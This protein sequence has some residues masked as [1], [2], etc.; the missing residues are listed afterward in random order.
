MAGNIR[1]HNKFHAYTHYTDPVPG[2]PGSAMDPIASAEFPFLGNLYVAGCLSA[3]GWLDD[4]GTCRKFL[5]EEE[6]G[7][8]KVKICGDHMEGALHYSHVNYNTTL[9]YD[10]KRLEVDFQEDTF[11]TITCDESEYHIMP[12][13]LSAGCVTSVRFMNPSANGDV[14]LA[15]HPHMT[16][17]CRRPCILSAGEE[18]I[19]SMTSFSN[20]L[21]SVVCIWKEREFELEEPFIKYSPTITFTDTYNYHVIDSCEPIIYKFI[22]EDETDIAKLTLNDTVVLLGNIGNELIWDDTSWST[23]EQTITSVNG[24]PNIFELYY[25]F[26]TRAGG[27]S[28]DQIY[29]AKEL[30]DNSRRLILGDTQ[31]FSYSGCTF[32]VQYRA[33]GSILFNIAVGGT[34]LIAGTPDP[35]DQMDSITVT[36]SEY[37]YVNGEYTHDG[38]YVDDHYTGDS[39]D[40]NNVLK[41]RVWVKKLQPFDPMYNAGKDQ[42][43]TIE[44]HASGSVE[45]WILKNPTGQWLYKNMIKDYPGYRNYPLQ[46]SWTPVVTTIGG[47]VELHIVGQNIYMFDGL[48][49]RIGSPTPLVDE[50]IELAHTGDMYGECFSDWIGYEVQNIN[51]RATPENTA[52]TDDSERVLAFVTP[53]H[54]VD[55]DHPA[56]VFDP[57]EYTATTNNPTRYRVGDLIRVYTEPGDQEMHTKYT[58]TSSGPKSSTDNRFTSGGTFRVIDKGPRAI[59]QSMYALCVQLECV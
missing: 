50:Y 32:D 43:Y 57:A 35:I 10:P 46:N 20:T 9:N 1:F 21:S 33:R 29:R 36:Q 16:W 56:I 6:P 13:S 54:G 59:N 25:A 23:L 39:S 52:S 44:R 40:K 7:C 5:F 38:R 18:A 30:L 34:S 8:R 51:V 37:S 19:L 41:D 24:V 17:M 15:W 2:I 47:T 3:H 58:N 11:K 14:D 22:L 27:R 28:M 12:V 53:G 55:V 42:W 45:Y 48:S 49:F 4:D 26:Q 31:T